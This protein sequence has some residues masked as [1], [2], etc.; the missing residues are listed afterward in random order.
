MF[1][2]RHA[3]ALTIGGILAAKAT[4]CD[5]A[6]RNPGVCASLV[7]KRKLRRFFLR[8]ETAGFIQCEALLS[9]C[10]QALGAGCDN[11][12]S[13]GSLATAAASRDLGRVQRRAA[14]GSGL[15]PGRTRDA[16]AVRL[17]CAC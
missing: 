7:E 5:R 10:H 1:R 11:L 17:R 2:L 14:Q 16:T 8:L 13:G 6:C 12:T 4:L 15:S 3:A 9:S